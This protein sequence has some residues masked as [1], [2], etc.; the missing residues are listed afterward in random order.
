MPV[1]GSSTETGLS[2]PGR[3]QQRR[4]RAFHQGLSEIGY[5]D[6]QNV[7]IEHR[8]RKANTTGYQVWYA[9]SSSVM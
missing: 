3:E 7:V 4:A 9:T 6:G 5:V 1:I 2:A 8:G